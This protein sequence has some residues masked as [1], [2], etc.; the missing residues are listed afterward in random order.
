SAR[1][2]PN[3]LAGALLLLMPSLSVFLW[4]T[5]TSFPSIARQTIVGLFAYLGL[6][7]LYWSGSR[8]GWLIALLLAA[9][10]L[11]HLPLSRLIRYSSIA[12]LMIAGMGGFL[13][14]HASYFERGATSVGARFD[15]WRAAV[16]TFKARPVF[17]AGPGTFSVSYKSL[18]AAESEMA[19]L[20]HNDYLEQA[21]D[22]G[23]IG[24]LSYVSIF[25]GFLF[26]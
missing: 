6:A 10:V 22:S 1:V 16:Q 20:T 4:E 18:K 23:I 5:T 17:G 25:P 24:F 21:S 11:F 12:V 3:A 13:V 8:A 15:Y 19:L 26:L 7:C 14:K 2:Y 9:V